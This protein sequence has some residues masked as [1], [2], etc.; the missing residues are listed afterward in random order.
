METN[1]EKI[2]DDRICFNSY[3]AAYRN[4]LQ[5]IVV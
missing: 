4:C 5:A 2:I 3:L 1:G